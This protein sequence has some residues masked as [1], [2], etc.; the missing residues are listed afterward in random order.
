[1]AALAGSAFFA[2]VIAVM[3]LL[4]TINEYEGRRRL[5]LIG[6]FMGLAMATRIPS[7]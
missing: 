2:H 5:W 7:G 6:G 1:V 3:L 4:L